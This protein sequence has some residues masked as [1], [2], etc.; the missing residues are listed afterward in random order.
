MVVKCVELVA[1]L[2]RAALCVLAEFYWPLAFNQLFKTALQKEAVY[3]A[4]N[5]RSF[6][7]C[8]PHPPLERLRSW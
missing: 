2:G 5:G 4:E 6:V 7:P 8:H 3:I 1:V